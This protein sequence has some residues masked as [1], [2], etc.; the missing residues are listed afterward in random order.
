MGS[1]GEEGKRRR[2]IDERGGREEMKGEGEDRERIGRRDGGRKEDLSG[3]ARK[4]SDQTGG[5]VGGNRPEGV[6]VGEG[7][8]AEGRPR[9]ALGQGNG[10]EGV[11]V[12][13][14]V[15]D[16]RGDGGEKSELVE[17]NVEDAEGGHETHVGGQLGKGVVGGMELKKSVMS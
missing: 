14:E 1:E 9:Q 6:G 7:G 8:D 12:G 13:E 4:S 17:G 16:L 11:A 15:L 5:P 2:M 10:G 3:L